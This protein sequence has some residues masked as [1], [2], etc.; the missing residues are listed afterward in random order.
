MSLYTLVSYLWWTFGDCAG[1]VASVAVLPGGVVDDALVAVDAVG[2]HAIP[3]RAGA[4]GVHGLLALGL[5][6]V[7]PFD[8]AAP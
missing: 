2:L 4:H 1:S 5:Q 6:V 8:D 3:P 7:E